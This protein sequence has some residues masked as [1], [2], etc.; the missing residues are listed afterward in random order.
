MLL[1]HIQIQYQQTE[2]KQLTKTPNIFIDGQSGTTG[3]QILRRLSERS[4]LNLLSIKE[5]E[6]KSTHSN[7]RFMMKPI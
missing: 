4:D 6:R 3:L 2:A 1:T 7:K 5:S